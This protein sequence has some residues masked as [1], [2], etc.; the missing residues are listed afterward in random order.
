MK[1]IVSPFFQAE[2]RAYFKTDD[3]K[4]TMKLSQKELVKQ[5]VKFQKK[6]CV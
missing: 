3:V 4:P 5:I 6:E 2:T 1:G